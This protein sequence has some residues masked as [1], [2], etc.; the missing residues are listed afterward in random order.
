MVRV[1]GFFG[2]RG[3]FDRHPASKQRHKSIGIAFFIAKSSAV[4]TAASYP[5]GSF[6]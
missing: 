2:S 4:V 1:T 5:K 6:A 3:P